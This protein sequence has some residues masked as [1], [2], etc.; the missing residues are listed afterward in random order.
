MGIYDRDYEREQRYDDSPGF[1]LGGGA[2]TWTTNLVI[3]MG[4]IYVVQLLTGLGPREDGW[5][6]DLFSSACRSAATAVDGISARSRMAFCTATT[7]S[8]FSSIASACGCSAGRSKDSMARRS[9]SRS[10]SRRWRLPARRGCCA[11]SPPTRQLDPNIQ[12]LGASGGIAAV[13]ILFCLNFPRQQI[14]IW[15]V[16]PMKAWVFALVFRRARLARRLEPRRQRRLHGPP[17]RGAV[18]GG[19]FQVRLA[20]ESIGCPAS[21]SCRSSAAG[22]RC[23]CTIRPT[24]ST[25]ATDDAV[26]NILRKIREHGQDSLTSEERRILEEASREYQKRRS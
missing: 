18:R 7:S 17:R 9:I 12:M 23:A 14:F 22:R 10:F 6:T 8:T 16:F 20:V 1:H 4:I 15:G 26:D 19:L 21:G 11:N 2:R 24:I 13:L 25:N 3:L 5:F